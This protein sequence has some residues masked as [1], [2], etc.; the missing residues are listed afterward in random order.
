MVDVWSD[1]YGEVHIFLEEV[2]NRE[3]AVI[4]IP[5]YIDKA[6]SIFEELNKG[7]VRLSNFD[8]VIAKSAKASKSGESIRNRIKSVLNEDIEIPYLNGAKWNY[9]NFKAN[10]SD[11]FSSTFQTLFLSVLSIFHNLD[12]IIENKN[13]SLS[14]DVLSKKYILSLE[15]SI[16]IEKSEEVV[17]AICRSFAFLQT[18]CGHRNEKDIAYDYMILPIACV[19]KEDSIWKDRAKIETL[20]SWFWLSLFSGNYMKSQD[21]RAIDDI[22]LVKSL[23]NSKLDTEDKNKI[24][25]YKEFIFNRQEYS[26]KETLLN[27]SNSGIPDSVKKG[28]LNFILSIE[29]ADLLEKGEK[30]SSYKIDSENRIVSRKDLE[31]HHIMPLGSSDITIK[32]SSKELRNN[33]NHPLNSPINLTY[34]LKDTNRKI[35]NKKIQEYLKEISEYNLETH[36]I[37]NIDDNNI[38]HKKFL[39]DR[40]KLIKN[41]V[42]LKINERI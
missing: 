21:K 2:V 22:N 13:S 12:E 3:I 24:E 10:N 20:R 32:Q 30:I 5:E 37:P 25:K 15:P 28:I 33:K 19:L 35:G 26:D 40:F 34:I 31:I 4:L 36:F 27:Q 38:D 8:L 7:G 6:V 41:A 16:I 14:K 42:T 11:D 39:E 9:S 1:W 18:M 17:K 29:P 23:V